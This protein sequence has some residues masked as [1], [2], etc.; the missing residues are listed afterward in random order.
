MPA[1]KKMVTMKRF[2]NLTHC[3]AGCSLNSSWDIVLLQI[4]VKTFIRNIRPL[5]TMA[6]FNMVRLYSTGTIL[7][8]FL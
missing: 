1:R 8:M 2:L 7:N 6:K 5:E 4:V 3:L